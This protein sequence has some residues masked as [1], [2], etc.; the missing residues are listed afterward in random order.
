MKSFKTATTEADIN[1]KFL[2]FTKDKIRLCVQKV[3]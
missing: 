2:W 1:A 3:I